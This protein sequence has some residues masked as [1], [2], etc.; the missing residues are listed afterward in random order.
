MI[1]R[2][3]NLPTLFGTELSQ[4]VFGTM[5]SSEIFGFLVVKGKVYQATGS[6]FNKL[7]SDRGLQDGAINIV[8]FLFQRKN[9]TMIFGPGAMGDV[10]HCYTRTVKEWGIFVAYKYLADFAYKV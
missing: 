3:P 1:R 2:G 10:L 8:Q 6:R 7:I 5:L 4:M 9:S